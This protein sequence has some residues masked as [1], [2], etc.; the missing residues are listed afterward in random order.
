MLAIAAYVVVQS[1]RGLVDRSHPDA[2]AAGVTL[3]AVS[4]VVLPYL[5]LL[6]LRV[7]SH[8]GS[9][10]LRG[11]GAL[12]IASAALA[13]TTLAALIVNSTFGWWWGDPLAALLIASALATEAMRVL[14]RHRFG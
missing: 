11:D 13:A 9:P 14:V 10:A 3:A 2:S 5:G 7:A 1:I 12:T 8:L 6:K 4:L